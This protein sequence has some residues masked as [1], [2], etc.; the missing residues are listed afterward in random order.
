M[1]APSTA[2]IAFAV[3]FPMKITKAAKALGNKASITLRKIHSSTK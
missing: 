2:V 1:V 3:I